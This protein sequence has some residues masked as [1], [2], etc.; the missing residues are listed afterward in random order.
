MGAFPF[1][2]V[3]YGT[4]LYFYSTMTIFLHKLNTF[5]PISNGVEVHKS[6]VLFHSFSTFPPLF[7]YHYTK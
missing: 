5:A 1:A 6:N 3:I 4:W 7:N 2:K